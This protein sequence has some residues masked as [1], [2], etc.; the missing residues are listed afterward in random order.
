LALSLF[1]PESSSTI[2]PCE[3]ALVYE[4]LTDYDSYSEWMPMVSSSRLLAEE[5]DLAIAEFKVD[6]GDG[7]TLAIECIHDPNR[8]VLS[9]SIGG[10]LPVDKIQWELEPESNGRC[11]VSVA[12]HPEERWQNFLPSHRRFLDP[13]AC[14]EGLRRQTALFDAGPTAASTPE[15]ELIFRIQETPDGLVAWYHG[16]QYKLVPM[17][18]NKP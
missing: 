1:S 14:L 13:E 2:L 9:R 6:L 12:M 11:K 16:K 18:E 15:G 10:S 7:E 4:I 5:G 17:E 3:P 8:M